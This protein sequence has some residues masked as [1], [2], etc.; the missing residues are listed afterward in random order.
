MADIIAELVEVAVAVDRD[1]DG[2]RL[3]RLRYE[4]DNVVECLL[5]CLCLAELLGVAGCVL[6]I[7]LFTLIL[8]NNF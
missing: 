5:Y 2:P 3:S 1:R 6:L 8:K 7:P 4:A